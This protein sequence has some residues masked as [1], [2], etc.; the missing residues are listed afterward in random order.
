MAENDSAQEKTQEATPKKREDS[1]KKGQ[2]PR[3]RELTTTLLLFGGAAAFMLSGEGFFSG[4]TD[5]LTRSFTI[6]RAQIFDPYMPYNATLIAGMDGLATLVPIFVLLS[7]VAFAGPIA[8]GGWSLSPESIAP[9]LDRIDPIKG[10]KKVFGPNGLIEVVKSLAKF[11][12]IL[13]FGLTALYFRFDEVSQLGLRGTGPALAEAG[14]IIMD[15][16]IYSAA[17]TLVIAAIDVPYQLWSHSKK[18]RMSFQDIKDENKQ[19]EG[20]PELRGRVRSMQQELANRRMMEEV[21]KADVV[22]TN[23]TH[24]AVALVFDSDTMS[25][26]RVVAKGAD[27]VAMHIRE[28]ATSHGVAILSAPPLARSIFNTTKLNREI[29]PGLYVAVAQILAY[30]FQLKRGPQGGRRQS[31]DDLPIPE[32]LR[33]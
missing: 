4:L 32:E 12:L 13:G 6:S 3:S 16:F 19:Q 23:P 31:F 29:P 14:S 1:K 21:P 33:F 22:I 27:E 24:Y 10:M 7:I 17:A 5:I 26:P 15:I 2:V 18:L 28:L 11:V 25:A 20:S 8:I 30:V 9:K